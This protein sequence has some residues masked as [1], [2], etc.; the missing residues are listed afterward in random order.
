[1]SIITSLRKD[2]AVVINANSI[3][4]KVMDRIIENLE[5]GNYVMLDVNVSSKVRELRVQSV[6]IHNLRERYGKE[7]MQEFVEQGDAELPCWSLKTK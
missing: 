6:Y 7:L 4:W 2:R 3:S 1:V 5:D